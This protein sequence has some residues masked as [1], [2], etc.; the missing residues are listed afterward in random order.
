MKD[1]GET[2]FIRFNG[3]HRIMHLIVMV[4]FLGLAVTGLPLKY[5]DS[6]WAPHFVSFIGGFERA[7]LL[8]RV[9]ALL[10]F[11]YFAAHLVYLIHFFR[12][13]STEPLFGFILGPNSMVPGIKDL[14]DMGSNIK[15]FLGRGP[16]PRFDRWTYWEKFDYWAVFWGVGMIGISGLF[17]WFPEFFSRFFP[18]WILNIAAVVHSDEAL[19]ATGFIFIFHFGHTHLRGDK[20]PLDPVIFTGRISE[21][22]MK[23]ER[24][25]EYDRLSREGRLESLRSAPPA[26]WLTIL[27]YVVGFAALAVGVISIILVIGTI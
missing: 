21:G 27:S 26:P 5:S 9:C 13:R 14:K 19:L 11:G 4:S 16:K 1:A 20:F 25:S 15:W 7:G 12:Y 22:E 3:V 2:Y 24:P 8:H 18:G 23:E 17:L 10:T 6:P